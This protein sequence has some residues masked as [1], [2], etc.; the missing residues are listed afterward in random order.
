MPRAG[1]EEQ[2][3]QPLSRG[4]LVSLLTACTT[5]DPSDLDPRWVLS[6]LDQG[7][8][9]TYSMAEGPGETTLLNAEHTL[10]F[11]LYNQGDSSIAM[12]HVGEDLYTGLDHDACDDLVYIPPTAPRID[13]VYTLS[14]GSLQITEGSLGREIQFSGVVLS[15]DPSFAPYSTF[16][17]E[18][19]AE[20][21]SDISFGDVRV[22][23]VSYGGRPQPLP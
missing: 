5:I 2:M 8:G 4:L 12:L 9:C 16:F 17:T 15:G 22:G 19:D 23:P 14:E 3:I 7:Y 10:R 6:E 11:T 1:K 20:S 21:A 13:M 18:A